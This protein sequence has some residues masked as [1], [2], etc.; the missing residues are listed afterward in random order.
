MAERNPSKQRR[1]AQNR[2]EREA[3]KARSVAAN[4]PVEE[5]RT[6][7]EE[8]DKRGRSRRRRSRKNQDEIS[9]RAR[10]VIEAEAADDD[11]D[12]FEAV[13]D[14]FDEYDDE[15]DGEPVAAPRATGGERRASSPVF[16]ARHRA[17]VATSTADRAPARTHVGVAEATGTEVVAPRA[18]SPTRSTAKVTPART[19]SSR[20]KATGSTKNAT[21]SQARGGASADKTRGAGRGT[22]TPRKSNRPPAKPL[23]PF[24]DRFGGNE[25][26]GRWVMIS[27]G[28]VLLATIVLN[29]VHIVPEVVEN[30]KGDRVQTGRT[31]TIWH[32]GF[33]PAMYYLLP[34]IVILGLFILTARPWD[35]RRS[36]NFALALLTL[37]TFLTGLISI[38]MIPIACLA[39]G[40]WQARKAALQDV[41]GDPRVLREVER[42]RRIAGKEELRARRGAGRTSG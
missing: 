31:F 15:V 22:A 32:F 23:P 2:A 9:A 5:R 39:W 14:E 17:S 8:S 10:S 28:A 25:P 27:F 41:G 1:Q 4:T 40:C 3:R 35:R 38:Y 13:D 36:W 33:G 30:A 42:E 6:A 29:F 20:A 21:T 26:G 12:E 11:V 37:S 34:P 16:S 19:G 18:V 7:E 24:F